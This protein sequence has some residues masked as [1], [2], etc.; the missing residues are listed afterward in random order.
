MV[1]CQ[2]I[3]ISHSE[4]QVFG[5]D[6]NTPEFKGWRNRRTGVQRQPKKI[7]R[8]KYRPVSAGPLQVRQLEPMQMVKFA[9]RLAF[10]REVFCQQRPLPP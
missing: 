9:W 8:T 3:E 2:G 4:P 10:E 7:G 6:R 5:A 1:K